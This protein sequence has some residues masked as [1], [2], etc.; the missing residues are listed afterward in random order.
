M[1]RNRIDTVETLAVE[2]IGVSMS[3]MNR[4][5]CGREAPSHYVIAGLVGRLGIKWDR[6]LK[7]SDP[8]ADAAEP[9]A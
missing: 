4:Q 8:V 9:A 1:K 7:V 3:T 2:W 5:L 6:L